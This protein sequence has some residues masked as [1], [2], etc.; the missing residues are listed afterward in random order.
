M[1]SWKTE[2]P[3]VGENKKGFENNLS[4]VRPGIEHAF[5]WLTPAQT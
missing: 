2:E 3:D 4:I 1:T 5:A